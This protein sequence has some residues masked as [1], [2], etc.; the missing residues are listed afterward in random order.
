MAGGF[1]EAGFRLHPTATLLVEQVSETAELYP[2]N[3]VTETVEFVEFP[4]NVVNDAGLSVN[5]KS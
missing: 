1:T 4:A 3:E 2:F 5:E